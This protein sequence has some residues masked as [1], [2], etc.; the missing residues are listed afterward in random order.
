MV[1][2][3]AAD[4]AGDLAVQLPRYGAVDFFAGKAQSAHRE[5]SGK[6]IERSRAG[7]QG[8]PILVYHTQARIG[9]NRP[10][11]GDLNIAGAS[12][13]PHGIGP[14]CWCSKHQLVIVTAAEN[15]LQF[16]GV[17]Q[18]GFAG[19]AAHQC[20]GVQGGADFAALKYV[21]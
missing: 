8:M 6:V 4:P 16:V 17:A 3:V 10:D 14:R 2:M 15:V 1:Y 21:T 12:R 19:H 7:F 18:R 5:G 13:M 11:A 20:M 9:F